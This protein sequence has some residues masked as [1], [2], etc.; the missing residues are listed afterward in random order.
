MNFPFHFNMGPFSEDEL[1]SIFVQH[2][3][4][5]EQLDQLIKL[6]PLTLVFR[7][8]SATTTNLSMQSLKV[9]GGLGWCGFGGLVDEVIVT[10]IRRWWEMGMMNLWKFMWPLCKLSLIYLKGTRGWRNPDW[11]SSAVGPLF[12]YATAI[13]KGD[14]LGIFVSRARQFC[15]TWYQHCQPPSIWGCCGLCPPKSHGMLLELPG[16]LQVEAQG[17]SGDF[18]TIWTLEG[19]GWFGGVFPAGASRI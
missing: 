19:N 16:S 11:I 15:E 12:M 10:V 14:A 5:P 17:E 2:P 9:A 18:S 6:R 8:T 13:K 1:P 3:R 7:R 4:Q